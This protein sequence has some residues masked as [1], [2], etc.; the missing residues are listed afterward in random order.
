[1]GSFVSILSAAVLFNVWAKTKAHAFLAQQAN[2][3]V[4][5]QDSS[6]MAEASI[7]QEEEQFK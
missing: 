2:G 4:V 1:V 5:L 7:D 6:S 3:A